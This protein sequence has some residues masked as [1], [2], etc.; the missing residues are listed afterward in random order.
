MELAM[1]N[2]DENL[3]W[4][5]DPETEDEDWKRLTESQFFLGY[6]ECDSIYDDL[7]NEDSNEKS[8]DSESK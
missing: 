7:L 8:N 5:D 6:D 1:A 4:T 2:P 3:D